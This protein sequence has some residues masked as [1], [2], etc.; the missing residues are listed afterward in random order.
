M[1]WHIKQVII[2]EVKE[3]KLLIE[4]NPSLQKKLQK[5]NILIIFQP[6]H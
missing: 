1:L 3:K 6:K 4:I 2:I 5:F